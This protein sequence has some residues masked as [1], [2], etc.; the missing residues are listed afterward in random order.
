[1]KIISKAITD[2]GI[3]KTMNQDSI[4]L[5]QANTGY[6]QLTL[7]VVCDGMGGLQKGEVASSYVIH[8][9]EKWFEEE[10]LYC[11][12]ILK[13]INTLLIDDHEALKEY[14]KKNHLQCGTTC[15]G[16][17]IIDTTY[18]L[19]NIGDS[20]IYLLDQDIFQLTIDDT[21]LEQERRK[22]QKYYEKVLNHPQRNALVQCIGAT[23]TIHPQLQKGTIQDHTV[24]LLCSDGF[25]H[26]IHELEM[27]NF[28]QWNNLKTEKD[29]Q[30][31]IVYLIHLNKQRMEKDNISA[32]VLKVEYDA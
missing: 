28:L 12:D 30:K 31:S 24:F 29:I 9:F 25:R 6:K 26:K 21:Y 11:E 20:R 27:L 32:I 23:Q 18:Y 17:L 13:S 8:T 7:A 15:T 16:I 4:L 1:M 22:G 3:Y 2:K 19:F 5:M 14:G 10:C